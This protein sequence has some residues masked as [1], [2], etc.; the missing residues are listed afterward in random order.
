MQ[1]RKVTG[2][3]R[4]RLLRSRRPAGANL[5]LYLDA[6]R[7]LK[8]GDVVAVEVDSATT[9]GEKM[10]KRLG[11]AASQ[12]GKCLTWLTPSTPQEIAFQLGAPKPSLKKRVPNDS[13]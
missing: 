3:E 9:R 13:D 1:Y 10:R 8:D 11:R 6:L 12:L 7:G 4:E 5:T 2:E